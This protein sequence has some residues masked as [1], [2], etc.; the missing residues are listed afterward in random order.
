MPERLSSLELSM[1][2]HQSA[3]SG[4][5]ATVAVFEPRDPA[6]DADGLA[7]G[8]LA[9]LVRE[10]IA[11]VSRYRQR[12]QPVAGGL[13]G[14]VWVD[15]EGFDVTAHVQTS[16]LPGPGTEQ[17]LQ[18]FVAQRLR[19]PLDR[20]RPL[21]QL[22]LVT[23]L[24]AGRLALVE[25][26]HAALVDG[27]GTVDLLQVLFDDTP[28]AATGVTPAWHPLPSPGPLELLGRALWQA[29]RDPAGALDDL[30]Q[31]VP[32]GL[33]PGGAGTPTAAPALAAVP[34]AGLRALAS[35]Q[36]VT[37][38]DVVLAVVTGALRNVRLARFEFVGARTTT[39]ALVPVAVAED[40][41][42]PSALGTRVIA[43]RQRLPVGEPDP[44]VRLQLLAWAT[45]RAR[46]AGTA[47][48]ATDLSDLAGFAPA[49]LHALGVRAAAANVGPDDWCL[50]NVPGPRQPRF[51][52]EAKLVSTFPVLPGSGGTVGVT[53]YE[54]QLFFGLRPSPTFG[55][56]AQLLARG[57]Q[58]AADELIALKARAGRDPG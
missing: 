11:Y 30:R 2:A 17:Q 1:L 58:E 34:L 33:S 39:T 45:R 13:A 42:F 44:Q 12:V 8:G 19:R 31:A 56:D 7:A 14:A 20:A 15:D 25:V 35:A 57:L 51:L 28:R 3:G 53:S 41:G 16:P 54:G 49:T 47:T 37:V 10:R 43:V 27:I 6:P 40:E 18:E 32:P 55:E 21:W 46:G 23:G 5:L 50:V 36:E 4:Q 24:E 29:R 38:H 9:R 22:H 48:S 26:S 52:G